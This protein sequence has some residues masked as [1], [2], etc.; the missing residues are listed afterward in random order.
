MLG[1]Y[2]YYKNSF[3]FIIFFKWKNTECFQRSWKDVINVEYLHQASFIF[4][5][6]I[7]YMYLKLYSYVLFF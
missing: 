7:S 4:I 1:F 2:P 5:H 6:D 3:L